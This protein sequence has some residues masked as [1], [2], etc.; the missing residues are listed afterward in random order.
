MAKIEE[1]ISKWKFITYVVRKSKYST[2]PGFEGL[3]LYHVLAYMFNKKLQ[4]PLRD[5]ASAVAFNL[6][7]AIPAAAIFVFTLI[8]YFPEAKSIQ[9]EVFRFINEVTPNTDAKEVIV[10][11]M[12]D[13]FNHKKTGLLS[14][15][16]ILAIFYSSNAMFGI[17]RTFDA[18]LT[19]PKKSNFLKKRWR[20]MKLTI[21]LIFLLIITILLNIGQG[22]LFASLFNGLRI[23]PDNQTFWTELLRWV[24]MISLFLF[25]IAFT[26]KYA[27]SVD[28]RW[29][30]VTPGAIFATVLILLTT[31]LFSIWA[32]NFS[33]Y[34]KVYGSIGALLIIMVLTYLDALMLLIGFELD[35][36]IQAL[37]AKKANDPKR[38][39]RV[40]KRQAR[41]EAEAI[42]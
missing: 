29:K 23:N 21:A 12:D 35:V 39:E 27:P 24:I 15:G 19:T 31:W 9:D 20:A 16:L 5:R 25:S 37:C 17:I 13:L 4:V 18:T 6:I 26:Y 30:L 10:N 34:N 11:T 2:L 38:I 33:T 42:K 22:I 8:P 32:Q 3:P 28:K 36:S 14:V 7:M 40:K 41:R 1:K